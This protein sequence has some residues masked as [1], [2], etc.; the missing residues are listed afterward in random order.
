MTD[1]YCPECKKDVGK[2]AA[3]CPKCGATCPATGWPEYWLAKMFRER[4]LIGYPL[5]LAIL[6]VAGAFLYFFSVFGI[7][8]LAAIFVRPPDDPIQPGMLFMSAPNN[9]VCPTKEL[10]SQAVVFANDHQTEA[11][12]RLLLSNGGA[13]M[14]FPSGVP[15]RIIEKDGNL[16]G[17][18]LNSGGG[19]MWALPPFFTPPVPQ[20]SSPAN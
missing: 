5:G 18:R 13:C 17:F 4:P 6:G 14:T 3:A 20:T 12:N 11:F 8:L 15:V 7:G 19:E 2:T 1:F 9:M 10:I 16:I